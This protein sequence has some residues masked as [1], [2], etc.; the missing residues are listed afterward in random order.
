MT[1]NITFEIQVAYDLFLN[2]EVDW[3]F[4][5][6]PIRRKSVY[7]YN[8]GGYTG[9]VDF[10]AGWQAREAIKFPSEPLKTVVT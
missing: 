1:I 2:E 4:S 7:P 10:A 6:Q 5:G 8:L 3:H 9:I